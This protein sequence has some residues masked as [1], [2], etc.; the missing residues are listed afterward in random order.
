MKRLFPALLALVTLALS[1]LLAE[2]T[3]RWIERYR[4]AAV[5][6][7]P[8]AVPSD[9]GTGSE[10]G[11]FEWLAP[12]NELPREWFLDDPPDPRAGREVDPALRQVWSD[13]DDPRLLQE[14]IYQWNLRYL[15]RCACSQTCGRR[16]RFGRIGSLFYFTPLHD[17]PHPAYRF[18]QSSYD[19]SG[20]VTNSFGWRSPEI[21]AAKPERTIR[22]AFVGASTTVSAHGSRF[23]APEL[24]GHWLERWAEAESLPVRIEVINAGRSGINSLDIAGVVRE[25]LVAVEPDLVLYYEG[26]NQFWPTAFVTWEGEPAPPPRTANVEREPGWDQYS[27]LYARWLRVWD[28]Y[29]HRV[30]LEPR[31]V[32]H[33]VEWPA[34]LDEKSPDLRHPRLPLNLPTILGDLDRIRGRLAEIGSEL[35]VVSFVWLVH[36]GML[37]ELPQH[38]TIYDYL[39]GT[40]GRFSYRHM[41]RMA[42]FQN[43]VF[44]KYAGENGLEFIDLA[45][46][47]PRDPDLFVDAIHMR[48]DGIRLRAW[49]IAQELVTLLR[50]R[51]QAGELPRPA[52]S[53]QGTEHPAFTEQPEPV[54]TWQEVRAKCGAV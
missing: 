34:D 20:L 22:L 51:L 18:L 53:R 46:E 47:F 7:V 21:V 12:T 9:T 48:S 41:R 2:L 13:L 5:E 14:S 33:V 54:I 43:R 35:V 42:D 27:A 19:P 1:M 11:A 3:L 52:L 32:P 30:G 39:N 31:K 45:D 17:S 4:I 26:S 8:R 40:F 23:S 50:E 10:E 29:Y 49:L 25:E 6:L 24:V 16:E 37:L 38:R 28:R 15:E 44:E 36:D